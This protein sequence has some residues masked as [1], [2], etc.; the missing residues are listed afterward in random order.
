MRISSIMSSTSLL[1]VVFVANS[2][3]A[4]EAPAADDSAISDIVVT[5]ERRQSSVQSTPI[6]LTAVA[7]ESLRNENITD[8]LALA[9][10]IPNVYFGQAQVSARL[11]IRGVGFNTNFPGAEARVAYYIDNVY[12]SRPGGVLGTFYDV[13]RVEVLRGPQGTLY[14]RNATAGAINVITKR[15]SDELEGYIQATAGN[16]QY[17]QVEA[18]VGGP[19]ADGVSYRLSGVNTRQFKGYGVNEF[20]GTE[21]N[22][23]N[24]QS[25]RGQLMF[26]PSDRLTFHLASSYTHQ[27]DRQGA[28]FFVMENPDSPKINPAVSRLGGRYASK[29]RNANFNQDPHLQ[30]TLFDVSATT[31]L[32]L[33]G[34]A[35][36]TAIVG[37]RYVSSQNQADQDQTQVQGGDGAFIDR[38]RQYSAELRF[39]KDFDW[40]NL[41]VGGFYFRESIYGHVQVEP[42]NLGLLAGPSF[43]IQGF[44]VGGSIKTRALAGFA[45]VHI[46]LT[47]KLSV[48]I[49]A[50]YGD[51]RK[52]KFDEFYQFSTAPYNPA[53]APII[54]RFIPYDKVSSADFTP[55]VTVNYKL[56]RDVLA[57]ATFSQAVKLGGFNLG[58]VQP[59]FLTEKLTDYEAGVKA[60]WLGGRL[61]TNLAAFYYGYKNL[62]VYRVRGLNAS[63]ENAANAEL[64]GLEAEIVAVPF[65][66]L[67]LTADLGLLHSE[68][69]DYITDDEFTGLP[70]DLSGNQLQQAPKYTLGFGAEYKFR[71]GEGDM[72]L[73]GNANFVARMYHF[74]RNEDYLSQRPYK[75]FDAFVTYTS[76][77]GW[78]ASLFAKNIANEFYL[79]A[80]SNSSTSLYGGI[81]DGVFAPP[82]TYGVKLGFTY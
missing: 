11:S 1:A 57:Y 60:D 21:V 74:P 65:P 32:D 78:S 45:Q 58:G 41:V 10:S 35:K 25:V 47:N 15:P 69:K 49:G 55:K 48:D 75:T 18:G 33:G 24:I 66:G 7:G 72:S 59:P 64:Y 12:V 3:S 23:Q 50:R 36:L 67:T 37:Y 19:I 43:L 79:S 46:D 61:R 16:Y 17:F 28:K 30:R 73:K 80:L 34:D 70:L 14:G 29:R 26:E 40:G 68:Y 54:S 22:D 38:S 27:D 2:A 9:T 52:E 42:I 77:K 82:R 71:L 56:N 53:A 63:I 6:A 76:D 62:Q 20:T 31:D 51:E 5:A 4:Q 8:V 44:E 39:S 81:I 13:D